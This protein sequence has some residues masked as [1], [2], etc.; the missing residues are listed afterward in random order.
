MTLR[1]QLSPIVEF[2]TDL[3]IAEPGR[4]CDV[5]LSTTSFV[6]FWRADGFR[7]ALVAALGEPEHERGASRHLA[8]WPRTDQRPFTVRCYSW[9]PDA[10]CDVCGR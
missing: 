7:Q 8:I 3:G 2:L 9:F 6:T 4:T 5:T 1:E 10:T